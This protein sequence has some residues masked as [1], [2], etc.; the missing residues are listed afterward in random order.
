MKK[1]YLLLALTVFLSTLAAMFV[2]AQATPPGVP[3]TGVDD[4]EALFTS[5]DP[6]LH[7]NKQAAMHIVRDLLEAGRWDEASKWI[8]PEYIQHNPGF[9]S[10]LQTVVNAFGGGRGGRPVPDKNNWRTKVVAVTAEGDY[11]TVATVTNVAGPPAY[12]TTHFDMW[13]F[14]DGKA[15]EHWDEGRFGGGGG[16]GRGAGG[17]GGGAGG[18]GGGAGGP[19][20]GGPGAGGPGGAGPGAGGPGAGRGGVPGGGR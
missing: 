1:Q 18:P 10:G 11:V 20:R 9:A 3:V 15:D 4:P 2:F 8:T 14:K 17:P 12:T 6:K 16:G 13:R 19:G 5:K 7:A